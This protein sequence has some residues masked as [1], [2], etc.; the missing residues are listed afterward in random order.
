MICKGEVESILG[1]IGV[2]LRGTDTGVTNAGF[3]VARRDGAESLQVLLVGIV[4]SME[5]LYDMLLRLFDKSAGTGTDTNTGILRELSESKLLRL[6]V[7]RRENLLK[8]GYFSGCLAAALANILTKIPHGSP[9]ATCSALRSIAPLRRHLHSLLSRHFLMT[10]SC[11]LMLQ[12]A[13][14]HGPLEAAGVRHSMVDRGSGSYRPPKCDQPFCTTG[15][16]RACWGSL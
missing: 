14:L 3:C 6:S 1:N 7:R 4:L 12:K 10:C 8:Q 15:R 11:S 13:C 9:E 5:V 16:W 2:E